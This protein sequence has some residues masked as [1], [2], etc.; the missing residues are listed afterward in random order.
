[1][2]VTEEQAT[3]LIAAAISLTSKE[4]VAN[5]ITTSNPSDEAAPADESPKGKRGRKPGAAADGERCTWTNGDKRCKN[6][7]VNSSYCTRHAKMAQQI[8]AAS[9][10]N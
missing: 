1:M 8:S 5:L 9:H 7:H 4:F 10:A 6:K 3:K 2:R